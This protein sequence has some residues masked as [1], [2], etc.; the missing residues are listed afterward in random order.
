MISRLQK[1]NTIITEALTVIE[2]KI[3]A[4]NQRIDDTSPFRVE[5]HRKIL[6]P[7][8]SELAQ[9]TSQIKESTK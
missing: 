3:K 5:T 2:Q 1:S 7:E 8:H 4:I 9:W 6:N